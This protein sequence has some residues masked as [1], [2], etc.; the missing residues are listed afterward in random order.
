MAIAAAALVP[1]AGS[2]AGCGG[3]DEPG[4]G[5][6]PAVVATTTHVADIAANVAGDRAEVVGILAP[7]AD[8]HDYEPRPS[9]AEALTR[10]D[11]VL[12][13][14]GEL[15]LWLDDLIAGSGSEAQVIDL[16]GSVRTIEGGHAEEG[17]ED[18]E[19]EHEAEDADGDEVDPHWWQ[20]LA[21]GALAAQEIRDRLIEADPAGRDSYEAA[22]EEYV[23][24]IERLDLAIESCMASIPGQRRKLV[25]SHDSLGYF[26]NR[27]RIEVVGSTI[28][29]LTTQAQPSAGETS[30]LID[31]IREED[32]SAVF[33]EAGLSGDLERAVAEET[34]ASV[35]ADLYAD[36]L[37]AEG[38]AATYLGATAANA[39]ALASGFST[40]KLRCD[41]P[42]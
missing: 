8:P 20:S 3:G 26:A 39:E 35:G 11:L 2:V 4:A 25:S 22:T 6:G 19:E 17:H 5:S 7:G 28:P 41:L 12:R 33:A 34:G 9:D 29:A 24:E 10:A 23:R 37:A 36:S 40:G 15:D 38:P 31:L 13:S 27:Y 18:E 21:N 1:L 42:G 14:G 16:L 30:E 32:V